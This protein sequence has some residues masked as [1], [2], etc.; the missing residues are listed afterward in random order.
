MN[1]LASVWPLI[2]L[3]GHLLLIMH[4]VHLKI[5]HNTFTSDQFCLENGSVT[6]FLFMHLPNLLVPSQYWCLIALE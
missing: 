5:E 6:N 4:L 3:F 1:T 2:N